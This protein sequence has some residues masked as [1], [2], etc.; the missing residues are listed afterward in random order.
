MTNAQSHIDY[1]KEQITAKE[2][3]VSGKENQ[4]ELLKEGIKTDK[5][6]LRILKEGLNKMENKNTLS[7][8]VDSPNGD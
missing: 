1:L 7:I 5:A 3:E 8:S 2:T 6:I 4:V